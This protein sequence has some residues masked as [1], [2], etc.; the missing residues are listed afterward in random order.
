MAGRIVQA[1]EL[2]PGIA[3]RAVPALLRQRLG[4]ALFEVRANRCAARRCVDEN[5]SPRLAQPHRRRKAGQ[6]DEP[7]QCS[8]RKRV[9]PETPDIATPREQLAQTAA[10][11]VVEFQLPARI[12]RALDPRRH[13]SSL[14]SY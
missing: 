7:L 5:K 11:G 3:G 1:G 6:T 13:A 2:E 12:R 10:K 9:A 8:G 14:T 4:V